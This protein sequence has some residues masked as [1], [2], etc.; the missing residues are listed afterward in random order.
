MDENPYKP[1][2]S[3]FKEPEPPVHRSF[4]LTAGSP[5]ANTL[6]T[7]GTFREAIVFALIIQLPAL[8]LSA[9]IL[10]NGAIF[11]RVAIASVAFWVMT[12]LLGLRRRKSMPDTD[13]LLVKWGYLP[14]L[15]VTC[16]LW[17]I[18]AKFAA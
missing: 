2:V 14:V 10:D 15:L 16:V 5:T 13:I 3:D 17:G 18:A 7:V 11:K 6:I 12:L 9:L 1:P 4:R 8:L